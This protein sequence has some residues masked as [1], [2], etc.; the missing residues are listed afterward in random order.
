MDAAPFSATRFLMK[1]A[2]TIATTAFTR[3]AR[4]W[5]AL[6]YVGHPEYGFYNGRKREEMAAANGARNGMHNFAR[7]GIVGR[8][9]PLDVARHLASQG[10]CV[11]GGQRRDFTVAELEATR[12]EAG[13]VYQT[14]DILIIRSGWMNWYE[15]ADA[16]TRA[17][18]A[19]D[20]INLLQTPGISGGEDMAE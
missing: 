2:S 13:V 19:K 6:G 20:S 10:Q 8:G 3:K 9:A 7:K 4:Q 17:M 18:L 15:S 5:D 1:L 12:H 11:D 14:G 16:Q